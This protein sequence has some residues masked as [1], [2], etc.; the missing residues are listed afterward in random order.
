MTALRDFGVLAG[1][2]FCITFTL[3]ELYIQLW[4]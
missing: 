2:T 1:V 3:G 4:S